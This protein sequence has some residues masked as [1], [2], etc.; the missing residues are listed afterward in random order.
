MCVNGCVGDEGRKAR[1]KGERGKGWW[2]RER[3]H[4]GST[5][6]LAAMV[7]RA[8]V[9]RGLSYY[10]LIVFCGLA[11]LVYGCTRVRKGQRIK[12]TR[13]R[14]RGGYSMDWV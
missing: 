7:T 10:L 12:A 2:K 4:T 8:P 3:E 6:V 14:A 1:G 5:H 11:S 13:V 9:P